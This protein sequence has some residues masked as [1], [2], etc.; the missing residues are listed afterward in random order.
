[1]T[2][3]YFVCGYYWARMR[4]CP[5]WCKVTK[6]T[7]H[8]NKMT[9]SGISKSICPP[10]IRK[11][12]TL[13][14]GG[15]QGSDSCTSQVQFWPPG[16]QQASTTSSWKPRDPALTLISYP[17]SYSIGIFTH[18]KLRLADATHNFKWV[19]ILVLQIWQHW[20]QLFSDIT[21]WFLIYDFIFK[22]FKTWYL[23]WW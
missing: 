2:T 8:R 17:P 23:M 11:D 16:P 10:Y 13:L 4:R 5:C 3:L 14:T 7:S 19:E 6:V 9:T 22:M 15:V 12:E 20:G 18:L 1:M 21:D